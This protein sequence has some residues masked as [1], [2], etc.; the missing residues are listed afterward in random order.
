MNSAYA[1]LRNC[2]SNSD[3]PKLVRLRRPAS[4][5]PFT[6]E[7]VEQAVSDRFEEQ[8]RLHPDRFA[9]KSGKEELTY[10]ELN[11]RANGVARAILRARGPGPEPV[12]LLL[13]KGVAL[14]AAILGVLKA[15]KFY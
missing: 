3:Q 1:P 10:A 15:G 8:V 2:G 6:Q 11:R 9:V 13:E 5:V 12:A 4:F 14:V 7:G